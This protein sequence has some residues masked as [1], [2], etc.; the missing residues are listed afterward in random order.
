[1]KRYRVTLLETE[2]EELKRLIASG[3]YKHTKQKRAQILLAA[4]ES[5]WGKQMKDAAIAQAYDVQLRT[6]E[7]TRQRFVEQGYA[8]ALH[9]KPGE[10]TKEKVFDSRVEANLI[11]LRCSEVPAGSNQWSLRLLADKMVELEYVETISHES[12]R[13]ILKKQQRRGGR[14]LHDCGS[15]GGQKRSAHRRGSQ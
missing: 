5:P 15:F 13:Q 7:R 12:V 10:V 1:M 11:A 4:D 2:R 9:S 3:T 14:P 8:V 6:V